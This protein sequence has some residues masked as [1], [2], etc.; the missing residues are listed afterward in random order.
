MMDK[1]FL[2]RVLDQLVYETE[3][4]YKTIRISVPFLPLSFPPFPLPLSFSL[5]FP[6]PSFNKHCKEIYGLND[7][8]VDYVWE[9]YKNIIKDKI[10]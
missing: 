4:N 5:P 1:K 7:D 6:P 3:I 9:E 8:E 2:H 10:K